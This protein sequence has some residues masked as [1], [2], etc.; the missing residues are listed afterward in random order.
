MSD[1]RQAGSQPFSRIATAEDGGTFFADG[2]VDLSAQRVADGVPPM[3]AGPLPAAGDA[4]YLRSG[5]YDS[6]PHP[7]PRRQW[8]IML[9]G[10]IRVT[11]TD[12]ESREFSPGD[13]L[14]LEDTT[15]T[16]HVTEGVGDPPFEGL[17][18][19]APCSEGARAG[20]C[21]VAGPP[22]ASW[23]VPA[24]ITSVPD[25]CDEHDEQP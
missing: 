16:G 23:W 14:L 6:T 24:Q 17:F 1:T 9:R 8:V 19:P 13:L 11:V 4:I 2:Q 18:L 12:G 22:G 21:S 15:G 25:H 7:T 10:T 20:C 3:L 5:A